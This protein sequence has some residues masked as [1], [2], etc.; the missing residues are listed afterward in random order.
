MRRFLPLLAALLVAP[1]APGASAAERNDI[2]DCYGYAHL[3]ADQPAPS[4]REL[5]V[6][7]DQTTPLTADLRD[8]A[9][10]AAL[11]YV[12]PGDNVL[13]Y[14]FSAYMA[15]NYM[16]LPFEGMLEAPI[17]G[18]LRDEVGMESLHKL[19][20]CLQ[21]QRQ[22]FARTFRNRFEASAG[23]PGTDIAKSEILFSLRQIAADLARRPVAGRDI[24]LVSD[25]L[26]NSDFGSF[27]AHDNVRSLRPDVELAKVQANHL[28]ADFGGAR[29]YVHGAGLVPR[30]SRNGYRSGVAIKALETFWRQYFKRSNASLEAFGAPSLTSDLQ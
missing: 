8:T 7:V 28:F 12:R 15:D 10:K 25:M 6:I 18:S 3:K 26:E 2:P 20:R 14:Q 17:R 11:R 16:R 30:S 4:G 19:D 27:Y 23:H 21:Q 29:I 24:L 5:V 22:F 9:I 13:L 1:V